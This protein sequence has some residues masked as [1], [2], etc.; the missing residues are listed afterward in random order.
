MVEVPLKTG[1]LE[2]LDCF[3][4]NLRTFQASAKPIA[5]LP[6]NMMK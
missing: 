1:N 4:A 2:T 6:F 3:A 5:I